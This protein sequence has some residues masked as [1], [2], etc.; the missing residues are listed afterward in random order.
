MDQIDYKIIEELQKNARITI[1]QISKKVNLAPPTV[2]ER[3][4][5]LEEKGVIEG[6]SAKLNLEQMGYHIICFVRVEVARNQED[7][8][9]QFCQVNNEILECHLVFGKS[10][11]LLKVGA[12]NVTKLESFFEGFH[13]FGETQSQIILKEIIKDKIITKPLTE[14]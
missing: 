7:S 12:P 3:I 2:S 9:I 14:I 6:Y 11:F 4:I 8:F 1:S 10:S 5:K 13:K